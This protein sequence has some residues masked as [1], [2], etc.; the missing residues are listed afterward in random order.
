MPAHFP[1]FVI[2]QQNE[3]GGDNSI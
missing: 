2:W 1:F 3:L